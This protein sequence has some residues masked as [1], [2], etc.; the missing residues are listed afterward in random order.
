MYKLYNYYCIMNQNNKKN[1]HKLIKN[2]VY[3]MK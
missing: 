3:S 2:S 1:S